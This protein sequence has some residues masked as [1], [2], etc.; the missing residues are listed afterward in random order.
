MKHSI[1]LLVAVLFF[2][3]QGQ[4]QFERTTKNVNTPVKPINNSNVHVFRNSSRMNVMPDGH[5]ILVGMRTNIPNLPSNFG[6]VIKEN[7][8]SS[9]T[10]SDEFGNCVSQVKTIS[11]VSS[12]FMNVNYNQQAIHIYPGAVYTFSNFFSGNFNAIENGR[13]PIIISTDNLAN[14]TGE[15]F[16]E[17]QDPTAV[18]VRKAIAD[19]IRPFST[20]GGAAGIQYRV[21]TSDNNADMSVKLSAGGGYAGF[22]ASA[23]ASAESGSKKIYVT[24]D[25]IKPMY[26]LVSNMPA[27][28]YFAD[29]SV[30]NSHPDMMMIKAVTYGARVLAN[31]EIVLNNSTDQINFKANFNDSGA[32][33]TNANATFDYLRKSNAAST[34]AN[35]YVVGGPINTTI[36]ETDKLQQQIAEMLSRCNYQTAQPISYSFS[37]MNGNIIGIE[38]ATDKFTVRNCTPNGSI[39]KLVSATLQIKSGDDGKDQGSNVMFELN[40]SAN[41]TALS[42]KLNNIPMSNYTNIT[43]TKSQPGTAT[44][45]INEDIYLM[46]SFNQGGYLNVAFQPKQVFLGWDNWKINGISIQLTFQDQNGALQTKQISYDNINVTLNEVDHALRLPFDGLFNPG[47]AY[48]RH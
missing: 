4:A 18:N 15:V 21:F 3:V 23:S 2:I 30:Y 10:S 27:N 11:A 17:V 25:A 5:L 36:F 14:S 38:T 22:N 45:N 24:I 31:V 19:I 34:T 26:S 43:L 42:S 12:S 47:G 7:I 20:T 9:S 39:F 32:A 40:N 6:G 41:Y 35:A 46:S 16:Q 8:E 1:L 44:G 28:G 37:D 13:N 29:Q 48:L 33:T